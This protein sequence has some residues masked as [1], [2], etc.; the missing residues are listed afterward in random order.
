MHE[1]GFDDDQPDWDHLM[2]KDN[3]TIEELSKED[4]SLLREYE[5]N[6]QEIYNSGL[7]SYLVEMYSY[8]IVNHPFALN[9]SVCSQ[10]Y[11]PD[12]EDKKHC[13]TYCSLICSQRD[14][15]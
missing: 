7:P 14:Q 6:Q 11:I 1:P 15:Y 3:K 4:I 9:C 8:N 12:E 13:D 10:S 2:S 5:N